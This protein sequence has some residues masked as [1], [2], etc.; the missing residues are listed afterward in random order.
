MI[1]CENTFLLLL[2]ETYSYAQFFIR[3]VNTVNELYVLEMLSH[4]E[5]SCVLFVRKH[6]I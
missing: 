5:T 1:L 2:N 4:M 6:I 3:L